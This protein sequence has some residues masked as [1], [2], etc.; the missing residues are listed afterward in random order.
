MCHLCCSSG[1]TKQQRGKDPK[2]QRRKGKEGY[3]VNDSDKEKRVETK[4]SSTVRSFRTSY[5]IHNTIPNSS[6]DRELIDNI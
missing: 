6:K 3:I 1:H 5:K 2:D 4:K